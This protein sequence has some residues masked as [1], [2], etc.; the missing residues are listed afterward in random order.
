MKGKEA[1]GFGFSSGQGLFGHREEFFDGKWLSQETGCTHMVRQA[2]VAVTGEGPRNEDDGEMGPKALV[3]FTSG[4]ARETTWQID[5]QEDEIDR[6]SPQE[7][8]AGEGGRGDETLVVLFGKGLPQHVRNNRI[9]FNDQDY[10]MEL[11]MRRIQDLRR[12]GRWSSRPPPRN[13][14]GILGDWRLA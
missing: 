10:H 11:L 13:C 3:G 1:R 2:G 4:I 9:I 12:A 14:Q 7:V 8:K 5:I 6:M